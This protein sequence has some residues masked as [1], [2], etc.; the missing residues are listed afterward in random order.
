MQFHD[1]LTY[2]GHLQIMKHY[3][4][5]SSEEY[6]SDSNVVVS[7]MGYALGRMFAARA[8]ETSITNFQNNYFQLGTGNNNYGTI[9]STSAIATLV[10]P[11]TDQAKY[12]TIETSK[13]D[14]YNPSANTTI[15][16]SVF[17]IVPAS[18]ITRTGPREVLWR[19]VVDTDSMNGVSLNEIGLFN[20]NPDVQGLHKSVLVAYRSWTSITKASDFSLE[21]RWTIEF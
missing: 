18:H 14:L 7:G 13:H 1:K 3:T 5:G 10:T 11:V 4:D 17:G 6:L 21:F 20:N 2:K 8:L 15:N 12:H 9:A 16:N 19:I